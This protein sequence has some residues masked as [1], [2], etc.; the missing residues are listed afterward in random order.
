M[1]AEKSNARSSKADRLPFE[2]RKV[3][4]RKTES[5]EEQADSLE[6][7][8]L[9][10]PS[11]QAQVNSRNSQA[12]ESLRPTARE[13]A[14]SEA[15]RILAKRAKNAPEP[16]SK[17]QRSSRSRAERQS[18][19]IPEVVT[20]RMVSRMTLFCGVPSLLGILAFLVSYQIVSHDWLEI[21]TIAVLFT[22]LG[23]F[24][25]GVV[26]LSYGAL[27]ASWDEDSTGSISGL[28]EFRTNFGR[29]TEAWQAARQRQ[30]ES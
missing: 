28:S 29:M 14:E 5:Q 30:K 16:D 9:G 15:A 18:S 26:G 24:G 2:P 17:S 3:L 11:P 13:K 19:G 1:P 12:R 22:S 21:P 10:K 8:R 6:S 7:S 23:C 27:S 4:R 25:L 20:R